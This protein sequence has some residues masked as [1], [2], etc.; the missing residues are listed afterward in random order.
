MTALRPDASTPLEQGRG[1]TRRWPRVRR[2]GL[3]TLGGLLSVAVL[4]MAGTA[5]LDARDQRRPPPGELVELPDGR[6]LHLQIAGGE[7]TGPTIVLDAGQGMFSPAF[8]WLQDTLAEHATVVAYDRPGYGWSTPA[9]RPVDADATAD[10]LHN[11]LT[12][13]GLDGPYLLVGHSLGAFYAH[14]F[15]ARHPEH[16]VGLVLLDPAH[17][18]QLERLPADALAE[19]EQADQMFRWAARMARL[20]LFRLSNPQDEATADLPEHAARQIITVAAAARYWQTAG[21]EVDAFST[22]AAAP[23]HGFG[24]LPVMVISAGRD[25]PD[26]PQVRAVLDELNRELVSRV[27]QSTHHVI[28]DA[29]HL[30]L[31]TVEAHAREVSELILTLLPANDVPAPRQNG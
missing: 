8:A 11:A 23:P 5:L 9:A 25:V 14:T 1:R 31:L 17:E 22:L 12:S 26:G 24:D 29:D 18:Q 7:H 13:H 30:T 28:E 21:A 6:M 2:A 16:T 20:G 3:W 27:P 10:D 4:A 15:A 19:F